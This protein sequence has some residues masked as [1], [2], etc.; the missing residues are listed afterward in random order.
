MAGASAPAAATVRSKASHPVP[1][2]RSPSTT[3]RLGRTA[4]MVQARPLNPVVASIA[5][6]ARSHNSL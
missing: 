3:A 2:S 6:P 5:A 1:D 4:A